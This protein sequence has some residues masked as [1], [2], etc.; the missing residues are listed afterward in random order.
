MRALLRP[1][2]APVIV[3]TRHPVQSDDEA[4]AALMMRAYIGTIDYEGEDETDALV[5]V[6]DTFSG[7]KGPFLWSAVGALVDRFVRTSVAAI[8]ARRWSHV[9]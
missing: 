3:G 6:R 2:A 7:G 1:I 4:L 8:T 5:E 9:L